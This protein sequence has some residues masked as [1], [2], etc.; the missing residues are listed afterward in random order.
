MQLTITEK[1]ENKLLDRIEI[2][3]KL[4]FSG[5]T[6]SKMLLSEALAKKLSIELPLIVIKKLLTNFGAQEADFSAVAY[7][8]ADSKKSI[9]VLTKHMKKKAAEEEKKRKETKTEEE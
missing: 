1:K 7:N 3:G 4:V 5:P 8:K 2:E 9:E 6:P